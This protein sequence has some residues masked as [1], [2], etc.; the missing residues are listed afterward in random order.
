MWVDIKWHKNSLQV[1]VNQNPPSDTEFKAALQ[2]WE[3]LY[4]EIK[5]P[6][7]MAV[8]FRDMDAL[9]LNQGMDFIGLFLK[10]LDITK[11]YLVCT[12]VCLNDNLKE[13]SN[14]FLKLYNP[15]R[16]YYVYFDDKLFDAEVKAQREELK[17]KTNELKKKTTTDE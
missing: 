3:N 11:K 5:S 10:V 12:C 14:I 4:K 9:Q 15:S 8:N 1:C 17:K 16:P 13:A 2:I 7:I 6:F